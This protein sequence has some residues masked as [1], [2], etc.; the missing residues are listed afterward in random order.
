[1]EGCLGRAGL[2]QWTRVLNLEPDSSKA[3]SHPAPARS[4]DP[5]VLK[6][7]K[8]MRDGERTRA[9]TEE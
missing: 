7:N 6:K 5:P 2:W 8:E 9:R 4:L 3:S 1:M